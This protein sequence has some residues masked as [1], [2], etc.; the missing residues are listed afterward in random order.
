MNSLDIVEIGLHKSDFLRDKKSNKIYLIHSFEGNF[1]YEPTSRKAFLYIEKQ[2]YS[3]SRHNLEKWKNDYQG[4]GFN[5]L[6]EEVDL[7]I[8]LF[9]QVKKNKYKYENSSH[10]I[11]ENKIKDRFEIVYIEDLMEDEL[12]TNRFFMKDEIQVQLDSCYNYFVNDGGDELFYYHTTNNFKDTKD[13]NLKKFFRDNIHN[14]RN[15]IDTLIHYSPKYIIVGEKKYT[16]SSF[17]LRY[18]YR[19]YYNDSESERKESLLSIATSLAF[20]S[21]YETETY[22]R[23]LAMRQI[24][25]L[26]DIC[27]EHNDYHMINNIDGEITYKDILFNIYDDIIDYIIEMIDKE[28]VEEMRVE[29][30]GICK[31]FNSNYIDRSLYLKFNDKINISSALNLSFGYR[32]TNFDRK[33]AVELLTELIDVDI[34]FK[35]IKLNN[36]CDK[37]HLV[38]EDFDIHISSEEIITFFPFRTIKL[39]NRKYYV[40]PK[41]INQDNE[42]EF[43]IIEKKEI[44]DNFKITKRIENSLIEIYSKRNQKVP[45]PERYRWINEYEEI[46][47]SFIDNSLMMHRQGS[48][49]IDIVEKKGITII[50]SINAFELKIKP[51]LNDKPEILY[52]Y[53]CNPGLPAVINN[54]P[55]KMLR[56]KQEIIKYDKNILREARMY[57]NQEHLGQRISKINGQLNKF[58]FILYLYFP[59]MVK[60]DAD[61]DENFAEF[62]NIS[63]LR[64]YVF[65]DLFDEHDNHYEVRKWEVNFNHYHKLKPHQLDGIIRMLQ[66]FINKQN[67][68]IWF[69]VG[70]GKTYM[71]LCFLNDIKEQLPKYIVYIAPTS[72]LLNVSNQ[73]ERSGFKLNFLRNPDDRLLEEHIN[74]IDENFVTECV[75]S[76]SH[77][78]DTLLVY[79]ECHSISGP[80]SLS[81][82]LALMI[83]D[84]VLFIGMTG[85]MIVVPDFE[86]LD[87]LLGLVS[88]VRINQYNCLS[89]FSNVII[90]SYKINLSAK[91]YM[92]VFENDR[93]I[94]LDIAQVAIQQRPC[95]IVVSSERD[96]GEMHDILNINCLGCSV[97][98][99][100]GTNDL[101]SSV[102]PPDFAIANI[103]KCAGFNATCFTRMVSSLYDSNLAQQEQAEGRINRA[104]QNER[105]INYY[106]VMKQNQLDM[107][108]RNEATRKL[109]VSIRSASSIIE[110][111]TQE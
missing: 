104:D 9:T 69:G 35:R 97:V 24:Y 22:R 50:L 45:C 87:D 10:Q 36:I 61:D 51:S 19:L 42:V 20:I 54:I 99:M 67:I 17:L 46:H 56:F 84:C 94:L 49:S 52:S 55:E 5:L 29:I 78:S 111:I 81:E 107:F 83:N 30:L 38:G 58:F 32:N 96:V 59:D 101:P 72:S 90:S 74:L 75:D 18:F 44:D 12:F 95:F 79:D 64:Q 1:P 28:R 31:L 71:L 39:K 37:K 14:T 60:I 34:A 48:S 6:V 7:T 27:E 109:S 11:T 103:S 25:T 66:R 4:E 53:R 76:W 98:V 21:N 23:N 3:N 82:P 105:Q 110:E 77:C 92:C 65:P 15:I 70:T 33:T 41:S 102:S 68:L 43:Y 13:V 2:W 62:L 73:I 93:D 108:F 85:T 91:R 88:P 80:N 106:Y 26:M 8:K 86:Y 16:I 89:L 47:F 100:D 40:T 63:F 57:F